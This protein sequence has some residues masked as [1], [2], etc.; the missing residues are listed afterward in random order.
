[1]FDKI[2]TKVLMCAW[3]FDLSDKFQVL[4][5]VCEFVWDPPLDVVPPD[6]TREISSF[7]LCFRIKICTIMHVYAKF[8][9]LLIDIARTGLTIIAHFFLE[10]Q[11]TMVTHLSLPLMHLIILYSFVVIVIWM[12][13]RLNKCH[14]FRIYPVNK[15]I[16]PL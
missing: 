13:N 12:W 10:K 9:I 3:L 7:P 4:T 14:P 6:E 8:F 2:G 11:Q 15:I 1:M 5:I 16:S